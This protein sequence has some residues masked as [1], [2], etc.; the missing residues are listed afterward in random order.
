MLEMNGRDHVLSWPPVWEKPR[1]KHWMRV[2]FTPWWYGTVLEPKTDQAPTF[3][4]AHASKGPPF[5]LRKLVLMDTTYGC[6]M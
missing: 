3:S 2:N 1:R 6:C 4:S 5:P